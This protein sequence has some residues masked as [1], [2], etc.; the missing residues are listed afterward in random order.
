MPIF[1]WKKS[2]EIGYPKID[3]QHRQ[4]VNLINELADAM[5]FKEG[6][7]IVDVILDSLIEYVQSHF[8]SEEKVMREIS[9]PHYNEHRREHLQ[10]TKKVLEFKK[11]YKN[12]GKIN[13][14][15]FL[16][17][18]CDWLRAHLAGSDKNIASF[19][20]ASKIR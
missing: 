17:F 6:H 12:E 1:L 7:S 5:K 19:L 14:G 16:D 13:L 15:E 18:L 20:A 11:S 4:L 10:L 3:Q 9:F 8:T 2:Y